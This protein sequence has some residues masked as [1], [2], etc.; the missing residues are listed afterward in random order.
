M[1]FFQNVDGKCE[2]AIKTTKPIVIEW[3]DDFNRDTEGRI[4]YFEAMGEEEPEED[5]E[6]EE[7]EEES[8]QE[9]DAE[10]T[11]RFTSMMAQT[12]VGFFDF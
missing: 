2:H 8:K 7:Q 12:V 10:E 3:A 9:E 4:N 5:E 1:N 6:E 11:N